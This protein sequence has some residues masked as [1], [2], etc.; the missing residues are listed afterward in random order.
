MEFRSL[1]SDASRPIDT[2]VPRIALFRRT[3]ADIDGNLVYRVVSW[4]F[5]VIR[6]F[7]YLPGLLFAHLRWSYCL[8]RTSTIAN[9]HGTGDRCFPE[10]SIRHPALVAP[11]Q[12]AGG[13]S[14]SELR[15]HAGHHTESVHHAPSTPPLSGGG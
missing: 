15:G 12:V 4:G 5:R 10:P 2:R 8:R 6:D 13:D 9:L 14:C 7:T 3:G 1:Y 11:P